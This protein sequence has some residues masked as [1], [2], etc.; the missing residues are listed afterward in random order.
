V[1]VARE[2]VVANGVER[3]ARVERGSLELVLSEP[4]GAAGWTADLVV[5]N[6][7]TPLVLELLR[8][9]LAK[10]LDPTGLLVVCGILAGV[11]NVVVGGL[12]AAGLEAVDCR[13]SAGWSAI[14]SRGGLRSPGREIG[15]EDGLANYHA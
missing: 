12:E 9:G 3:T 1:R 7:T 14:V 11:E 4:R 13:Q 10:A 8:E 2:N 6:L 5:A 15:T